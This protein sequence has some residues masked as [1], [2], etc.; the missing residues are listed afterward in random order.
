MPGHRRRQRQQGD[1]QDEPHHLD[2]QDHRHRHQTQE[3]QIEEGDR[4]P[5][6]SGELL[7]AADRQELP[8]TE[9]HG[10]DQHQVEARHQPQ[11]APRDQQDVA[12]EIAHEIGAV[13]R[14][15]GDEEDADG[16]P[17]GPD[18][19]DQGV[20]L[21]APGEPH[22][23]DDERRGQRGQQGPEHRVE[24]EIERRSHA[25]QHRMGDAAGQEGDA[26]DHHIGPHHPA[27]DPGQESG[28]ERRA[29]KLVFG[30]RR[31]KSG[32]A[33]IGHDKATPRRGAAWPRSPPH[34][35]WSTARTSAW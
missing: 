16:H 22:H 12:E 27:A 7:I 2:Q 30:E 26:L 23:A 17:D 5:P 10:Q 3:Q 21:S 31:Q 9:R 33:K 32:Y 24:A 34:E 15:L 25:A 18:G 1:H 29:Q 35:W 28:Q 6:Q 14:G 11:I 20:L 19:P 4:H 8:V 13:A